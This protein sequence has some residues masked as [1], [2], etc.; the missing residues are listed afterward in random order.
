MLGYLL[1]SLFP[2]EQHGTREG[3]ARLITAVQEER[4]QQ[5]EPARHSIWPE[6][7]PASPGR[8]SLGI[9]GGISENRVAQNRIPYWFPIKCVPTKRGP[10][11][12]VL[13]LILFG[14]PLNTT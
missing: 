6:G 10:L 13:G 14:F 7:L 12:D 3:K 11:S 4:R 8:E 9:R 1:V 2:G 5:Q